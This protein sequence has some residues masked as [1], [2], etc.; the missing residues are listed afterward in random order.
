MVNFKVVI[1]TK[2]GKCVQKEVA[3]PQS[4][5]LLGMKLGDKVDGS[6]IGFDGYEFEIT[7]GS[8]FCGVPMRKEIPGSLRKK[9]FAT[10]GVGLKKVAKGIRVRKTVCGNTIYD[11]TVQINLKIL[12]EGAQK[13]EIP[14]KAAAEA[15][16]E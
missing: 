7:G 12:K 2:E 4:S 10:K 14:V 1:G 9:I 16:A 5:V 3:D 15:K 13:I 8:D 11:K 6:G